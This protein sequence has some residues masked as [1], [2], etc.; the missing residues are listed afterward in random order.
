MKNE[1]LKEFASDIALDIFLG[2]RDLDGKLI[3]EVPPV[4]NA[5][6]LLIMKHDEIPF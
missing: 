6:D 3:T 2:I 5:D 4:P 1:P